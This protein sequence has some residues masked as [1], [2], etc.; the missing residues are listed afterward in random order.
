ML[1]IV[2]DP[3]NGVRMH[4]HENEDEHFIILEGTACVACGERTWDAAA[5]TAFTVS[6]GVPHA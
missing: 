2:A 4:I 3:G 1:E 5:G 6:R